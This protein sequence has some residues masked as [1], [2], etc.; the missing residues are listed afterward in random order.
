MGVTVSGYE[1]C[2]LL[3]VFKDDEDVL[4]SDSNVGIFLRIY[5]NH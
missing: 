3:F 1:E 5:S 2:F 4:V